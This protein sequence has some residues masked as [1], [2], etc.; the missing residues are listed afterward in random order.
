MS[1][2]NPPTLAPEL[3][4]ILQL[5]R[6]G[7]SQEAIELGEQLAARFPKSAQP[8]LVIGQIYFDL[9]ALQLAAKA[10]TRATHIEPK[11]G[12]AWAAL[13][14]IFKMAGKPK[15]YMKALPQ[16][17]KH[18]SSND[19]SAA[20]M[21]GLT[22]AHGGNESEAVKWFKRA[23][24]AAPTKIELLDPLL[25]SLIY[26]N[27]TDSALKVANNILFKNP[28]KALAHWQKSKI[29]TAVDTGHIKEMMA[30]LAKSPP[31][32]HETHA[33]FYYAMGKEYEDLALWDEAF[34]A[35]FQGASAKAKTLQYQH[36]TAVGSSAA[37]LKLFDKKWLSQQ[38]GC[39]DG[40]PIFVL[41]LPRTG[42]TLLERIISTHHLV[43]NGGEFP[44]FKTALDHQNEN[45]GSGELTREFFQSVAELDMAK[46]GQYY[47]GLCS[48]FSN[49]K[50]RFVDK[51]PTNWHFI[52][53]ILAA[54]PKAKIVLMNRDPRDTCF[55]NYK[56]LFN[57]NTCDYSYGLEDMANH[58]CLFNTLTAHW[59]QEFKGR[60]YEM[61]YESLASDTEKSL[62]PLFEYLELAWDPAVLEFHKRKDAV[63]TAS[64]MQ[65]RESTHTRS[66][67]RWK[68]YEKSIGPMLNIL[69]NNKVI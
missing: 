11:L 41:G 3:Q 30:L 5:H 2:K 36:Q 9:R 43:E 29:E 4:K 25:N 23:V 6:S 46:V 22:F 27:K 16:A 54:L 14:L 58:Y 10:Y 51:L 59:A 56:Q 48:V 12:N 52:P 57:E 53:L 26:L 49:K 19:A 67:A 63:S 44:H 40:Q 69:E 68:R 37:N 38:K 42:T 66:I 21:L 7:K 62:V 35:F 1:K 8:V 64:T 60:F 39:T 47:L 18:F 33:Y 24:E 34:D 55:S 50:G 15:A 17:K 13:A 28:T 61:S 45:K 20:H 65:V 32:D 31:T